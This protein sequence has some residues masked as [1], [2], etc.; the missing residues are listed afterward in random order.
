MIADECGEI[1][2]SGKVVWKWDG[3]RKDFL[4]V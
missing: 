4:K 1:K 2:Y 3:I